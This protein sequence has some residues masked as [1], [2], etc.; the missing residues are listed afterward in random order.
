MKRERPGQESGE[1][2]EGVRCLVEE[3]EVA[4]GGGAVANGKTGGVAGGDEGESTGATGGGG[5]GMWDCC[6]VE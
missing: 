6:M 3:R 2:G 1:E 5:E 4:E